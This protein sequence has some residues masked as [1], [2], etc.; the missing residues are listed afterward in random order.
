MSHSYVEFLMDNNQIDGVAFSV[1]FLAA[2]HI[3][4]C[5]TLYSIQLLFSVF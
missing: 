4:E 1:G 5:L 3:Y 2:I